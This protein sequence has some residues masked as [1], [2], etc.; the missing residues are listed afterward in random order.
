MYDYLT[1]TSLP[2]FPAVPIQKQHLVP[3]IEQALLLLLLF[4]LQGTPHSQEPP[5]F[6]PAGIYLTNFKI[7]CKPPLLER[8]PWPPATNQWGFLPIT[9]MA[10]ELPW[11]CSHSTLH[12]L[13]SFLKAC[14][15]TDFWVI[16][17]YNAPFSP[18]GLLRYNWQSYFK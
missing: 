18:P 13:V 15:I 9:T 10:G 6:P 2:P 1:H 7:A 5:C 12:L 4:A 11:L 17:D 16:G 14:W 3:Q 8:L